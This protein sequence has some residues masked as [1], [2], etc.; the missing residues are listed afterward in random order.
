[1]VTIHTACKSHRGRM[2]NFGDVF[3]VLDKESLI[4][5]ALKIFEV[6]WKER[7]SADRHV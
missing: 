4:G 3:P 5:P 2:E 1:M 7:R 6:R